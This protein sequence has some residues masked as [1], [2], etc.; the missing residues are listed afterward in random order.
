MEASDRK[1]REIDVET[2][3]RLVPFVSNEKVGFKTV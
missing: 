2:I 1:R 3:V